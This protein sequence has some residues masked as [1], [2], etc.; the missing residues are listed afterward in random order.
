MLLYLLDLVAF[1]VEPD[2]K[3]KQLLEL[4]EADETAPVLVG[5]LKRTLSMLW[6]HVRP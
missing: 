4:F 5:R 6:R 3:A 2:D 1:F